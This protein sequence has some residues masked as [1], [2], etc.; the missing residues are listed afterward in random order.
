MYRRKDQLIT[1]IF[2]SIYNKHA[3]IK[4]K[5]TMSFIFTP[6]KTKYRGMNLYIGSVC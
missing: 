1:I 3:K 5:N 6:N 4:N 2:P